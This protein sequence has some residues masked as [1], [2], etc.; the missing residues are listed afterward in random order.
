MN[1]LRLR[2]FLLL[3]L[4]ASVSAALEEAKAS[5]QAG[6]IG[7]ETEK[8]WYL[9]VYV[10]TDVTF[11]SCTPYKDEVLEDYLE[12]FIG[13]VSLYFRDMKSPSIHIVYLGSRSLTNDEEKKII[14]SEKSV[15]ETAVKGGD[16]VKHM[17]DFPLT[18]DDHDN[19][20][21]NKLLLVLTRL[22]ITEEETKNSVSHVIPN[23]ASS[24]SDQDLDYDDSDE[25]S[26]P[27]ARAAL[28]KKPP[29]NVGGMSQ[30][31]SICFMS[32][33]IVQDSGSNFSGVAAA[34]KE[35][36]NVLGPMYNGTI[37]RRECSED[38][39][40]MDTYHGKQCGAMMNSQY[41]EE[42]FECLKDEI[43]GTKGEIMTPHR[44]YKKHKGWTPCGTSY[45]GTEE[46]K[47]LKTPSYPHESC[48][49]S[50]CIK[51]SLNFLNFM[52]YNI[53]APD[54]EDCESK[55]ICLGGTCVAAN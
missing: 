13:G 42:R 43:N 1:A 14:G 21:G 9:G 49:I 20:P 41:D 26:M 16:A 54:G 44:F 33:A 7:Q 30:Y 10:A 2:E 3:L 37:K 25:D 17:M 19:I 24:E 29:K 4:F 28:E 40:G 36:A 22:N 35:I 18:I 15:T 48:N 38:D 47:D 31:G 39:Q 5:E 55:K 52:R 23:S 32:G 50:C 11:R 12:A 27:L 51:Q 46:C 8:T 53:P 45:T 34:A 6:C